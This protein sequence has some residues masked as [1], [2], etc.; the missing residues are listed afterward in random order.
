[1]I[2]FCA[3]LHLGNHKQ[4]GDFDG[5]DHRKGTN[6]RSELVLET[7][8]QALGLAHANG[9]YRF[10][11][12]G[13]VFDKASPGPAL[14]EDLLTILVGAPVE[15]ILLVGN[16][17]HE[18]DE[19]SALDPFSQLEGVT[20]ARGG[21]LINTSYASLIPYVAGSS[22]AH[23]LQQVQRAGQPF[24]VLHAGLSDENDPPWMRNAHDAI[25]VH[26]LAIALMGTPVKTVVA[27]NWHN[28]KQWN[29][30]GIHFV[31]CGSVCPTGFEDTHKGQIHLFQDDGT[32]FKSVVVP[33]PRFRTFKSPAEGVAVEVD[34]AYS[35]VA[36]EAP[37]K[38]FARLIVP[39]KFVQTARDYIFQY[40]LHLR[41]RVDAD[42]A[43]ITERLKELRSAVRTRTNIETAIYEY[44]QKMELPAG[45]S[46]SEVLKRALSIRAQR[47]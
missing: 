39:E 14:T 24:L 23:I 27:G 25:D 43:G 20:V 15:V 1:M 17:D 18:S 35:F 2:A 42:T 47:P 8:N 4:F 44:V 33:G 19:V 11:I 46:H 38:H 28:P 10:V 34:D 12:C 26:T 9:A 6:A 32:F 3:D 5:K 40:A 37:N 16:H 30:G 45:V 13:D 31:Q 21:G 29:V 7:L 36:A 41:V 22:T